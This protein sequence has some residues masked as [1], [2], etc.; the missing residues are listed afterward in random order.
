MDAKIVIEIALAEVGYLEKKSKSNL[1]S[2]TANAGSNNYTKYWRDVYPVFQAQAWCQC[3]VVWCFVQAYGTTNAKK[4]LCTNTFSYA[5]EQ[6]ANYFKKKKQFF[7]EPA[8][9]DLIFFWNSNHSK[10]GHVG[11]VYKT[12]SKYVYTVEGNT[13]SGND[14]VISN[15][16]AVALKK[17]SRNN[18]RIGGYGRPAYGTE[19]TPTVSVSYYKKYQGNSIHIDEIFKTIGVPEQYRGTYVK[20]KPIA[21][22]NGIADYQGT[23]QQNMALINLAKVGT[24]K[25]PNS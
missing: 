7:T 24:L 13:S 6:S 2:K 5:C 4:L 25:K 23:F 12:D 20:R 16:G 18:V 3:F 10:F 15:G 21:L 9:G 1:D 8:E 22:A 19:Q 11:I 17:Y 14:V